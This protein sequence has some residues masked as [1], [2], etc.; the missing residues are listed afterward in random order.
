MSLRHCCLL[1]PVHLDRI[2]AIPATS[3]A[4]IHRLFLA[5]R[6]V[7]GL[8]VAARAEMRTRVDFYLFLT[9]ALVALR[10]PIQRARSRYRWPTHPTTRRLT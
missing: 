2:G 8:A 10:Q 5:L 7:N 4:L 1:V 6:S 3:T 9:A